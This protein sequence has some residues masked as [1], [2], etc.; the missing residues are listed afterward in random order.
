MKF[1]TISKNNNYLIIF[2][3]LLINYVLEDKY[4]LILKSKPSFNSFL[5]RNLLDSSYNV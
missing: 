4:R 5:Y 2:F 1:K 3:I